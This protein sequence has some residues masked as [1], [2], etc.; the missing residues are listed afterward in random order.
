MCN[1]KE[2]GESNL[3]LNPKRNTKGIQGIHRRVHKET[4]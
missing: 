3:D 1:F 2:A 4:R